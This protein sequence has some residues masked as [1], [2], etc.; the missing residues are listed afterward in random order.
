MK[1]RSP[2]LHHPLEGDAE[3]AGRGA[4]QSELFRRMQHLPA[5]Q[6]M[7]CK[8][9][10]RG[11]KSGRK[12]QKR[13]GKKSDQN[14]SDRRIRSEHHEGQ[15]KQV[16][17]SDETSVVALTQLVG[18]RNEWHRERDHRHKNQPGER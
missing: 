9:P 17:R 14:N 1:G 5:G 12:K 7:Q 4:Q 13:K 2:E 6:A 16:Q 10:Q 3:G 15:A 8:H 11:K 18:H